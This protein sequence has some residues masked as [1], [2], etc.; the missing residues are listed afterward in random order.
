MKNKID[1]NKKMRCAV[2]CRVARKDDTAIESQKET[3]RRFAEEND[4][5]NISVYS[6]NGFNGLN[7]NRPAFNRLNNDISAGLVDTVIVKDISRVGRNRFDVSEWVDNIQSKGVTL[8]SVIDNTDFFIKTNNILFQ[9]F[10]E[11]RAKHKKR[12]HAV[13]RKK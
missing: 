7:F 5:S 2:Y 8:K 6:D 4:Y 1:M 3:L 9:S 12:N 11:Y 13:N 10:N